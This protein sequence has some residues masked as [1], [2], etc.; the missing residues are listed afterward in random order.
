MTSII[1]PAL[2]QQTA[3]KYNLVKKASFGSRMA[4]SCSVFDKILDIVDEANSYLYPFLKMPSI[5]IRCRD[6]FEGIFELCCRSRY[7]SGQFVKA[8]ET[9]CQFWVRAIS[10]DCGR[11]ASI[12]D[13]NLVH[14]CQL[15]PETTE[16]RKFDADQSAIESNI[17]KSNHDTEIGSVGNTDN[18]EI[19]FFQL[20]DSDNNA[21]NKRNKK[22][23]SRVSIAKLRELINAALLNIG[24]SEDDAIIVTDTLMYAELR[25]NNQGIIKLISGGLNPDQNATEVKIEFETPV[26][27]RLNGGQRIGMVVVSKSVDIA[28]SKA[29]INGISIVGCSNY[30]SATGALGVWTKKIAQEGL[31]GIVMSQCNE[32]VAPHGSYEPIFGTNPLSI[33]IPTLPRPQILDMATSACAYYGI[34]MAEKE[35]A[36]IPNDIAYDS[37]GFPTTNPSE[38]LRGAIRVFDRSFKGSHLALMVELLAGA[39][40]GA[41]MENKESSKN[42][43]SLVIAI[44]PG[45]LGNKEDFQKSAAQMCERVKNAKRLPGEENNELYLPGERGDTLEE[46]NLALGTIKINDDILN[47]LTKLSEKKLI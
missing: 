45:L 26:S 13:V 36:D 37:N 27:A 4:D 40:T 29:K 14:T 46:E 35:R 1:S 10:N 44:D 3:I 34:K 25:A 23:F 31:I 7:D 21:N 43:G 15:V 19:N 42:W 24:Y 17:M 33:G 22:S 6:N 20:N 9:C 41:A 18:C 47:E 12:V 8:S 30:S 32:M 16:K 28:I 11:S 2:V 39:L 5:T 38:A